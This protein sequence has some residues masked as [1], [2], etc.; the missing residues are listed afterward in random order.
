MVVRI[1]LCKI[2]DIIGVPTFYGETNILCNFHYFIVGRASD[3][4]LNKLFSHLI[5]FDKKGTLKHNI[6]NL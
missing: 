3:E 5:E 6:N 1:S 2:G 4:I